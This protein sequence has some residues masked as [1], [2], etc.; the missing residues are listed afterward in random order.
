[1]LVK[2]KAEKLYNSAHSRM[3]I[4]ILD[5]FLH[6][7]VPQIGGPEIRRIFSKKL[8]ELF[9]KY[10]PDI[11][12]MSPGQMF[13][14]AVDKSTRAD[15][16][17]VKYVPTVL[18]LVNDKDIDDLVSGESNGNPNKQLPS[19]IARITKEA[20]QQGGLLSMR[21]IALI[22]K[23][24]HAD[25]STKRKE[26]ELKCNEILPTPA[27]LQDMGSGVTHK[28]LILR[29]ILIEKKDMNV[30]RSETMH[31]QEA[32]DRYLKDY[33]RIAMLLKEEKSVNYI[34]KVT[35]CRPFLIKQYR[36]IYFEVNAN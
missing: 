29:K 30:V 3:F 9:E 2:T 25:I 4:S 21:D 14:I 26:Y 6:E 28:S 5:R 36:E 10:L 34:A 17:K 35:N 8:I 12:R 23:R 24:Y 15:S 22:F 16:I 7:H 33:Q 32:I 31:T 19:T 1:M 11:N 13:W 20:Y 18:T 27:V